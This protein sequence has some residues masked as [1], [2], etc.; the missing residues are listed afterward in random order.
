MSTQPRLAL[1]PD[2]MT[3]ALEVRRVVFIEG[4]GVAHDIE[5]DG[6]DAEA[7]HVIAEADGQVVATG[8]FV[9][10]REAGGTARVGRMAVLEAHRGQGLATA[11]L[12]A[13]ES[14]ARRQGLGRVELHA[15]AYIQ[16]LYARQGYAAVGEPYVEAGI[17]HITMVKHL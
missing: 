1:T 14:E 10:Q 12:A 8:R 7:T 3:A 4:Q 15:Q 13:L 6:L 9:A 17:D 16:G 2:D 5:R 11:V